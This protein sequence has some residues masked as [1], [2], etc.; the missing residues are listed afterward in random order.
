MKKLEFKLKRKLF[1]DKE[2]GHHGGN[3][4]TDKNKTNKQNKEQTHQKYLSPNL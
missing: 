2:S 1:W 3:K 4:Q